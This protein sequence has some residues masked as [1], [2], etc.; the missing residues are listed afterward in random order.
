MLSIVATHINAIKIK[1]KFTELK[2]MPTAGFGL[3]LVKIKKV[4]VKP[5]LNMIKKIR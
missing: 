5:M 2:A 4:I 1:I 3:F